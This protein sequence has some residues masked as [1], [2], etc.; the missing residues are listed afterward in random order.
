MGDD[1]TLGCRA[2]K[3]RGAAILAQDEAS[4]VVYGMPRAVADAGLV[5]FV[6]PLDGIAARVN[7]ALLQR[8]TA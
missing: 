8:V 1:G 3:D 4:C 2:M 6:A 7:E 5:D